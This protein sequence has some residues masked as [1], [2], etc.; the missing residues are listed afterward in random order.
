[1]GQVAIDDSCITALID[2]I[3][4]CKQCMV[5]TKSFPMDQHFINVHTECIEMCQL[6]QSSLLRNSKFRIDICKLCREVCLECLTESQKYEDKIN[7]CK[8]C[9]EAIKICAVEC[10]VVSH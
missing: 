7:G 9:A 2:C 1:M 8:E 3:D 6:A 10:G 4:A 5:A